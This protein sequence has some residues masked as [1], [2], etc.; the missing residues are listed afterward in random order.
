M[1]TVCPKCALTLVVTAADLRIAQGYVRC[2]RCSSVF[3]ALA[4]LT[5]DRQAAES[6]SEAQHPA[7]AR[8]ESGRAVEST[9]LPARSRAHGWESQDEAPQ[10][11]RKVSAKPETAAAEDRGA[12]PAPAGSV[13]EERIPESALEFDP[14]TADVGAVFFEPPPDPAWTAATGTFKAMI[15]QAQAATPEGGTPEGGTPEGATPEGSSLEGTSREES[16]LESNAAEELSL[17]QSTTPGGARVQTLMLESSEPQAPENPSKPGPPEG[18]ARL[19]EP[20]P[21]VSAAAGEPGPSAIAQSRPS[22]PARITPARGPEATRAVRPR[23]NPR[24]TLHERPPTAAAARRPAP[25]DGQHERD[26]T[27][28]VSLIG[29]TALGKRHGTTPVRASVWGVAAGIASL[30]LL[31]QIVH[32][33][34]DDLAVRAG[35]NRPLTAL[36]AA[37][38]MPLVPRWDVRAYDV[39]QLGAVT[40]P[41]TAGLITVRASIKNAAQQA[42]PLPLLRVTLQDRFGNRIAA[43]DVAP[44]S[45]LPH[46]MP[47]SALLGAGQR[48]DAEMGFADPGASA[49]GFEIDACLPQRGGGIACANESATR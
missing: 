34:R 2:G 25:S 22:M 47:A 46:A 29:E 44:R 31:A 42:Q 41:A 23:P 48:I 17:E 11:A 14:S 10:P 3:N 19:G 30:V 28:A 40:S 6:L 4:R 7:A 12:P 16:P 32:H 27:A 33:Y 49:V 5:D 38:G 24:Q 8:S 39:R 37:L 26:L 21:S 45:Y 9:E 20:R 1:F 43:R 15:A 36:Y 18:R 35:L 13:E